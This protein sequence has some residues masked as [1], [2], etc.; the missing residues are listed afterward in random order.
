MSEPRKK[1]AI[2]VSYSGRGGVERVTNLLTE[3][4]L[5][6]GVRVD[7]LVPQLT[8]EHSESIPSGVNII[9]INK[10]H[11]YSSVFRL[12]TYL[13]TE[14]PDALLAVKHRAV[15]TAVL[16]RFISGFKGRLLGNIHT[17]ISAGLRH[18]STLKRTTYHWGMKIFYPLTDGII[19]V[20]EGVS[21]D[22]MDLTGLTSEKVNVIYNPV[23]TPEIHSLGRLPL[24]HPWFSKGAPP[25]ILGIGRL[26]EQKDFHTLVRA[27]SEVTKTH[28][29]RLV[30]LGEGRDLESLRT[31]SNS[32]GIGDSV[33]FPG[34]KKNP[35]K[36]LSKARM[37]VLSSKW[38]GFGVVIVE[39]MALG[40]PVVSTDCPSGPR[41]ILKDGLYGPL[42]PVENPSSLAQAIILVLENPPE[43]ELL[44]SASKDYIIGGIS[45]SYLEVLLD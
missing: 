13:K 8:G 39:A 34:F 6:H 17:N 36:F 45:K 37:L 9:R 24:E 11:T 1:I 19:G 43:E 41:E 35:Y 4:F 2:F 44:R 18:S 12:A 30:I 23:V 42:V 25:V 5:E 26:T 3:G 38:E 21:C 33:D 16:A 31:L 28:Q 15:I 20:S 14:K 27:F 29:C 40:T 32:L 10:R 7:L 22:I